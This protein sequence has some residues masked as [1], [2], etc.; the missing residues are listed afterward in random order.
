MSATPLVKNRQ[1]FINGEWCESTL[2][3]EVSVMFSPFRR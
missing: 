3:M 1:L 2:V